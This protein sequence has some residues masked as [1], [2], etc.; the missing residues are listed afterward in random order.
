MNQNH[1]KLAHKNSFI[2]FESIQTM[3]PTIS[4]PQ[5]Q[6]Q[7]PHGDDADLAYRGHAAMSPYDGV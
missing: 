3:S 1:N 2:D 5:H 6:Q 7:M 4:Q